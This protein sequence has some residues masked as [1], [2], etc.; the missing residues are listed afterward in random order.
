MASEFMGSAEIGALFKVTRQRVQQLIARPDFPA[1][2]AHL[3]M[4]KVWRAEDVRAW[5]V[6]TERLQ[7]AEDPEPKPEFDE[8]M[9]GFLLPADDEEDDSPPDIAVPAVL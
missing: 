9:R 7:P 6:K 2:V 8:P 3:A 5:G 4:G 1:P